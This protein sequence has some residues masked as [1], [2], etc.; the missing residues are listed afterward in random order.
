MAVK[1]PLQDETAAARVA[2]TDALRGIL[3]KSEVGKG[4]W[5]EW[6]K[7]VESAFSFLPSPSPQLARPPLM[8]SVPSLSGNARSVLSPED[9]LSPNAL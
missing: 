5:L 7:S 8:Y 9:Q 2:L 6:E 3:D 1:A 4:K